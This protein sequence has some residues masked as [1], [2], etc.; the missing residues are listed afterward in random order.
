MRI[1]RHILPGTCW[2]YSCHFS[3]FFKHIALLPRRLDSPLFCSPGR[4]QAR[5]ALSSR[6]PAD[7]QHGFFGYTPGRWLWMKRH[8]SAT[9]TGRLTSMNS[10]RWRR[11]ASAQRVAPHGQVRRGWVQQGVPPRHG[12]WLGRRRAHSEPQCRFS[13]VDDCV[14]GSDNGLCKKPPFYADKFCFVMF[15]LL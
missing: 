2:S 1:Y 15:L 9:S 13:R 14:R 10:R 12:Q 7:A 3:N 5:R 4:L 6:A 8:S 11:R